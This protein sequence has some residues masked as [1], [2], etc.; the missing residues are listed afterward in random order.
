MINVLRYSVLQPY[1]PELVR[2][3]SSLLS[4]RH[5]EVSVSCAT[6]LSAILSNLSTRRENEVWE[7]FKEEN[8][9]SCLVNCVKGCC[10][11]DK[12]IEYFQAIASLLSKILWRWP[13]SRFQVWTDDKLLD[14]L[15]D[16][17]LTRENSVQA[18]VLQLY[19]TLALCGNGARKLLQNGES[20]VEMMVDCLDASKSNLERIE[21]FKLA[22]CLMTGE[23]G[24]SEVMGLCC[25]PL[26]KAIVSGMSLGSS[27]IAKL[28]KEKVSLLTEACCLALITRWTGDHH[29]YFWKYGIDI[30]LLDYL[31]YGLG[32]IKHYSSI[33]ELIA[34]VQNGRMHSILLPLRPYIWDIL[35]WL[36]AHCPYSDKPEMHC[37]ETQFDALI[38]CA[39]IA[40]ME[41]NHTS[42]LLSQNHDLDAPGSESACRAILMMV[43]SPCKYISTRVKLVLSVILKLHVKGSVNHFYSTLN[44]ISSAR[45]GRPGNLQVVIIIMSFLC[46]LGLPEYLNHVNTCKGTR[47]LIVF[48]TWWLRNP[49]HIK[50]M[51]LASHLHSLSGKRTCCWT[52]AEDWEGEDIILVLC[53]WALSELMRYSGSTCDDNS[54]KDFDRAQFIRDL[55]EI[56]SNDSSSGSRW[57]AA[58]VLSYLGTYGFPSKFGHKI[59]NLIT[60]NEF[61]DMELTFSNEE[62]VFVHKIILMVRCPS[63]VPDGD[64]LPEKKSSSGSSSSYDMEQN[65]NI[66]T[67]V[68]LSARV[69]HS[70]FLKLLNYVYMGSL[71]ACDENTVKN[72]KILAK[73][74]NLQPLL[75]MLCNR[76]PK[77]GSPFPSFN[78][79]P[80]L[81]QSGY[82]LSDVHFE[83]K[84][85][86]LIDWKCNYCL[87]SD[88][89]MHVH[90]VILWSRC[91]YLRALFQSG[92]QES[93]LQIIKAPIGWNALVKL[94]GWM[95]SD[96]LLTPATGCLWDNLGVDEKMNE[97]QPYLELCWLA[98]FWL[99]DDL[100][101][102]CCPIIISCLESSRY[103]SLKVIQVAADLSQ[104]KLA[105]T[106]ATYVA[107]IFHH[108]RD[109]GELENL[110]ENLVEMIR[111]ASVHLTREV[112]GLRSARPW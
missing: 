18:A 71:Q 67:K 24:C 41:S 70:S 62:S 112:G 29:M 49:V 16:L 100:Y 7:I 38:I 98:E 90:K 95:Y 105:E 111:V 35:G 45:C 103:L 50:R 36:A 12:P 47:T 37:S 60:E 22:Q 52:S 43:Y 99:L 31:L 10:S 101:E 59:G 23:E 9:V 4:L 27:E 51:N 8:A 5:T 78:L 2:S 77:W 68:N 11:D 85:N 19:S 34:V 14:N 13:A 74:C 110:D 17:K 32:D 109:S 3:L 82:H 42:S 33:E 57:Y 21:A 25:K 91:E 53:L 89:H 106:A 39:C 55:E 86:Q 48:I 6:A 56:C 26:V 81:G 84:E 92:M 20:L 83:P 102:Q 107:P 104:W 30:V 44:S 93:R 76:N 73:H 63:L 94:V 96:E 54:Q 66:I 40:F 75:Y 69:D 28:S 80:A 15:K 72:L 65:N 108:L 64:V 46:Y 61:A 79:T 1:I 58:Y 97:L 87:S 88:P